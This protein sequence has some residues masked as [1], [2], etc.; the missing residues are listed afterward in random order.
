MKAL[1]PEVIKGTSQRRLRKLDI[2]GY[3]PSSY[4]EIKT[5]NDNVPYA[6]PLSEISN[7]RFETETSGIIKGK[8][9][10]EIKYYNSGFS[11]NIQIVKLI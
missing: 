4:P 1:W 5:T 3:T 6:L 7:I 8:Y 2:S 11:Q 10:G 9:S